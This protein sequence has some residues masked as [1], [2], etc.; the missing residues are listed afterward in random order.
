MRE[1]QN[2]AWLSAV[3]CAKLWVAGCFEKKKATHTKSR[4]LKG[5]TNPTQPAGVSTQRTCLRKRCGAVRGAR[6]SVSPCGG[7]SNTKARVKASGEERSA[8]LPGGG[9]QEMAVWRR[10]SVPGRGCNSVNERDLRLLNSHAVLRAPA[11]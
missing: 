1:Q 8:F 2:L 11:G 5:R 3:T 9:P 6:G 7:L 4:R 10:Q